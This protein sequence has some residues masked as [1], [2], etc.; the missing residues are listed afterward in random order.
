[1]TNNQNN[2]I[3]LG[4]KQTDM[5]VIPEDWSYSDFG[6]CI[7]DFRGGASLKPSDFTATGVKVLPK[8]GITKG[9]VLQ[10]DET[11]QQFC[12][13]EYAEKNQKSLVDKNYTIIVLRD[14]VPSGP[15]IGLMVRIPEKN[16]YLLAQGVYGFKVIPWKANS[17]FLIHLSNSEE[18]RRLMRQILVGSTQVHIRNSTIKQT[19]IP[20]PLKVEEQEAIAEVLLDTDLIIAKLTQTIQKKRNIKQGVMQELLTGKRRLPGSSGK[21]KSYLLPKVTCF[22]EGPGV[23]NTQ[24]TRRGVKLLNGTNIFR[25]KIDLDKTDR[26]ISM[27]EA[28]GAYQHFLADTGDIV[29]ASSGITVE[30]FD[31]KI[32]FVEKKHL[33]LCMNTSTIRFKVGDN[34]IPQFLY[35]FLMSNEFKQQIGEQA[36]GSAQL[37]FGPAH[38]KKIELTIPD[39]NEQNSIVQVLSD[40]DTEIESLEK[41]KAKYIDLKQ[42]MMQQLLTGKIRLI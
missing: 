28:F 10:I 9:G 30:K 7:F 1:M 12:S 18:Y 17:N 38:L 19:K 21:W 35:Y 36:T 39:T 32:A 24:F 41:Q 13:E 33:P 29:I 2:Q 34:M 5:G 40:M 6:E 14:L 8:S 3:S 15:N 26:F 11:D 22:Q 42:G 23:R 27:S 37:N 31:E 16:R 20:L 4:Y 25:G